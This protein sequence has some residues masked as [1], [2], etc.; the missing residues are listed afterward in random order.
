MQHVKV[1]LYSH[2]LCIMQTNCILCRQILI[3][4]PASLNQKW[5]LPVG[6]AST[7]LKFLFTTSGHMRFIPSLCSLLKWTTLCFLAW[8]DFILSR[9]FLD[10]CVQKHPV[11]N[12]VLCFLFITCIFNV[13][14]NKLL[15]TVHKGVPFES[16]RKFPLFM[17]KQTQKRL[18]Y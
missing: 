17:I 5:H 9:Y 10:N 6:L 18:R 15:N 16:K 11:N 14:L 4:T 7:A 2:T 12:P 1:V 8:S 13:N 3:F